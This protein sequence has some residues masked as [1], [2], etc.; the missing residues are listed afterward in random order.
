[1]ATEQT[2]ATMQRELAALSDYGATLTELLQHVKEDQRLDRDGFSDDQKEGLQAYCWSLHSGR[3]R[4][5]FSGPAQGWRGVQ[6][7]LGI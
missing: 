5:T 3:L 6:D 1:M 2:R 4:A 7:D